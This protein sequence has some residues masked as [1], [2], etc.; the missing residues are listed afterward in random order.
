MSIFSKKEQDIQEQK[1]SKKV[2]VKVVILSLV[3]LIFIVWVTAWV[4][5][6]FF[7]GSSEGVRT[8]SRFVPYPAIAISST[9]YISLRELDADVEAIARFYNVQDFSKVGV[10]VDFTTPE[11]KKRL[12]VR[13]RMLINKRIEER[14]IEDIVHEYDQIVTNTE[15]KE[16]IQRKLSEYGTAESVQSELERLYGWSLE[17]FEQKVVKPSL[18][19]E[20][21][22]KIYKEK[23]VASKSE[24]SMQKIHTALQEVKNGKDF[25]EVAKQYSEGSSVE[26]GGR[27]GYVALDQI[28]S[29]LAKALPLLTVGEPSEAIESTLGYHILL[30]HETKQQELEVF[31]DVSQIFVRKETFA[32]YLSEEI[33]TNWNIT[34]LL[35]EYVWNEDTGMVEFKDEEMRRFEES[36]YKDLLE[37]LNNQ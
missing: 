7:R 6:Y 12:K 9:K 17:D 8:L 22:E 23:M 20:K 36:I 10:R 37:S 30:L 19:K 29:T 2:S 3:L 13:E 28:D 34:P 16:N 11:G 15:A 26:E 32:D 25:A 14:V 24:E 1:R 21:A 18:Y 35:S 27:V 5:I 4:S 33:V 31:Y